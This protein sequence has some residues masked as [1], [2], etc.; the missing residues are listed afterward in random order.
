M[1][2]CHLSSL[3]G[4][5][6]PVSC[7]SFASAVDLGSGH[8]AWCGQYIKCNSR[9][10]SET[11]V[12]SVFSAFSVWSP[13]PRPPPR[14]LPCPSSC[15]LARLP[16]ASLSSAAPQPVPAHSTSHPGPA[17]PRHKEPA[18]LGERHRTRSWWPSCCQVS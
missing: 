1:G 12:H 3:L 16:G 8:S 7:S 17:P 11:M 4:T 14:G 6:C 10:R 2:F 15:D 13:R 5:K 9:P 18:S